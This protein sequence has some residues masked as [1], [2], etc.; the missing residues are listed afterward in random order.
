MKMMKYLLTMAAVIWFFLMSCSTEQPVQSVKHPAAV[1]ISLLKSSLALTIQRVA[2]RAVQNDVIVFQDTA[3]VTDGQ[4]TFS[5]FSLNSGYTSF[6]GSGIDARGRV[7][8]AGTSARTIQPGQNNN[9]SLVLLPAVPMV[10]LTPYFNG[11]AVAGS[12]FR[13][14]LELYH[15]AKFHAGVFNIGFDSEILRFDSLTQAVTS[16]G[17]LADTATFDGNVLRIGVGRLANDDTAPG[18]QQLLNIWFTPYVGGRT[19]LTLSVLGMVDN[20]TT[21]PELANPNFVADGQT[22]S[23]QQLSG[24][25]IITGRVSNALDKLSLDS[26]QVTVAGPTQRSFTTD[27]SGIFQFSE[28]PYGSY[29]ITVVRNGFIGASRTVL[30]SQPT[31]Q[32]NFVIT[33]ILSAGQYRVVLTW[34]SQPPDLDAH[35]FT[36]GNEVYYGNPGRLDSIPY[37]NLDTDARDG[38]GPET[39]T[40]GQLLDTCKFAVYN[41]SETP[42][43]TTSRAHVDI[44]RG[45]ELLR[46]F[47]VPTSGTGLWW[48]VFDLTPKGDINVKN[49]ITGIGPGVTAKL[50]TKA[51]VPPS[52]P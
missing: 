9:V 24:N 11:D 41:Y 50:R 10:K 20:E 1:S 13:A 16:W 36:L 27:T 39:I 21:I 31:L 33:P 23:I 22:V 15:I 6:S 43:I 49:V 38:F 30:L 37:A 4:F 17:S 29:V 26:V 12:S 19:S 18:E 14:A 52:K 48:Y 2:L 7:V 46:G 32:V 25:G 5:P 47:D 34:G 28:L 42:D 8:Y 3:T 51:A 40:I 35:L 44:Y 45:S